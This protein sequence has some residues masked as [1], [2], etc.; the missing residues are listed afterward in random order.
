MAQQSHLWNIEEEL[1]RATTKCLH[2]FYFAVYLAF[3]SLSHA[4]TIQ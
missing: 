2:V 3:E 4:L 1:V